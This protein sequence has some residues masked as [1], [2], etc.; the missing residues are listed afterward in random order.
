MVQYRGYQRPIGRRPLAGSCSALLGR[1]RAMSRDAIAQSHVRHGGRRR[2]GQGQGAP[3]RV[4]GSGTRRSRAGRVGPLPGRCDL[5]RSRCARNPRPRAPAR[6]LEA[7]RL[8]NLG[9]RMPGP[10]QARP[11]RAVPR[12]PGAEPPL[13]PQFLFDLLVRNTA[14]LIKLTRALLDLR[15]HVEVIEDIL[16]GALVGKAIEERSNCLFGF[17]D[18]EVSCCGALVKRVARASEGRWPRDPF[19]MRPNEMGAQLQTRAGCPRSL[20][21]PMVQCP[22]YQRSIGRRPLAV[23]CSALLGGGSRGR[24]AEPPRSSVGMGTAHGWG[25]P[26][27]GDV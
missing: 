22:G 21:V 3:R 17:R 14:A 4:I 2:F 27:G 12:L 10:R 6:V 8:G 26:T 5:A 20:G 13:A 11:G 1:I 7:L 24:G 9:R 16:E 19:T 15:Q 25:A 23:S 18:R